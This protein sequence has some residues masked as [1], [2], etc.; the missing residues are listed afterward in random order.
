MNGVW[1]PT[2]TKPLRFASEFRL[3]ERNNLP[4]KLVRKKGPGREAY[5]SPLSSYDFKNA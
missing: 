1:L 2:G 3:A 5:H 4:T